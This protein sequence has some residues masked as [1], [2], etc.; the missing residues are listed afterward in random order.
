MELLVPCALIA[1]AVA[2]LRWRD[3]KLRASR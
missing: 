1:I 2:V 3:R